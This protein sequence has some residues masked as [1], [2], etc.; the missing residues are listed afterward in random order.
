MTK[1]T[2]RRAILAGAAAGKD[3]SITALYPK[4]A[5]AIAAS[6]DVPEKQ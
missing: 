4:F 5:T 2:T 6:N 3:R 1:R